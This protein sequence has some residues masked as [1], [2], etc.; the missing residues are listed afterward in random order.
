VKPYSGLPPDAFFALADE[1]KKQD[2]PVAGHV[3]DGVGADEFA[4]QGA[5]SEEHLRRVDLACSNLMDDPLNPPDEVAI[6]NAYDPVKAAALFTLFKEDR[7]WQCPTMVVS[8]KQ[9]AGNPGLLSDPHFAYLPPFIATYYRNLPLTPRRPLADGMAIIRNERAIV[10]AMQAEGVDLL[11]G[12][13]TPTYGVY[14]GYGLH[15]ELALFVAAGLTPLQALQAATTNPARFLGMQADLGTV[16]TGKIA[17][18]VLLDANPLD[19]I[20][21]TQKIQAVVLNGKLLLRADLDAILADLRTKAA[22]GVDSHP[23]PA[24]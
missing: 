9:L 18:L 6:A 11:A 20:S 10:A 21:S 23:W 17:D 24:N 16:A 7:T 5:T 8:Y 13:D 12:T 1:C 19:D 4:Q 15:E 2:I 14:P 3:P 22:T